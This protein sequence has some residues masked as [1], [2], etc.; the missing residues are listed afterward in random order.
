[1]TTVNQLIVNAS[2][3]P[4]AVGRRQRTSKRGPY[5]RIQD[6]L[7]DRIGDVRAALRSCA[8]VAA[9][10]RKL[11]TDREA[12]AYFCRVYDIPSVERNWYYSDWFKRLTPIAGFDELPGMI[13]QPKRKSEFVIRRPTGQLM[14]R[15]DHDG[16]PRVADIKAA[17]CEHFCIA[18]ED[19]ISPRH[20]HA[21]AHPRQMA[22]LLMRELTDHSFPIIARYL[23]GRDHTTI[24]QGIR[25][26]QKRI[27]TIPEWAD[28]YMALKLHLTMR[29]AN[30]EG[31]DV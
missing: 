10:A 31:G 19:L 25:S 2:V 27:N 5:S 18:E 8:S 7:E 28:H 29:P 13:G 1:M 11:G 9:A 12:L 26:V 3:H 16:P 4:L 15:I 6:K 30:D 21:F 22:M 17:V 24:I 14:K 20:K 23:G